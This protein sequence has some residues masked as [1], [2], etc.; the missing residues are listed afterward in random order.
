MGDRYSFNIKCP[1]CK[2]ETYVN[3]YNSE[4]GDS[5]VCEWCKKTFKIEM[6][7]KAIKIK[8]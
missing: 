8:K 1:Y 2:K 5:D 7:F 4:W 3:C 6:K